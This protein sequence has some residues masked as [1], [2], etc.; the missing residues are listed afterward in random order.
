MTRSGLAVA[1]VTLALL[2]VA[3]Q[4]QSMVNATCVTEYFTPSQNQIPW[5]SLPGDVDREAYWVWNT[6]FASSP[7][8]VPLYFLAVINVKT[9]TPAVVKYTADNAAELSVNDVVISSADNW[10]FATTSTVSLKEGQNV[11]QIKAVNLGGDLPLT[12]AGLIASMT[13]DGVVVLRT[14]RKSW[15]VSLQPR[16]LTTLDPTLSSCPLA[17]LPPTGAPTTMAPSGAPTTMAP[18]GAPTTMASTTMAP[19]ASPGEAGLGNG[20]TGLVIISSTMGAAFLI[21]TAVFLAWRRSRR[22][23]SL[24]PFPSSLRKTDWDPRSHA[25]TSSGPSR[26][27]TLPS[28][29][30]SHASTSSGLSRAGTLPSAHHTSPELGVR[31]SP[32]QR[33]LALLGVDGLPDVSEYQDGDFVSPRFHKVSVI[34]K[35]IRDSTM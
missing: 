10:N 27:G 35:P 13:I 19:T 1:A 4:A 30:T 32:N 11:I 34:V 25:S 7:S 33:N 5:G 12:A 16:N 18:I 3:A 17:T 29:A 21:F 2:G 24:S 20:V 15:Q 26:A 9:A 8:N 23:S 14:E 31:M 28:D 6:E 22:P